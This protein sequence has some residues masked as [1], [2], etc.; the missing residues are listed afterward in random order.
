MISAKELVGILS[1]KI[2]RRLDELKQ[3]KEKQL[4]SYRKKLGNIES[5]ENISQ[6]HL[7]ELDRRLDSTL[8]QL[9]L[10]T[11]ISMVNDQ[12]RNFE[13]QEY[14][15]LAEKVKR[16]GEVKDP[17]PGYSP[18]K[19]TTET[20][21]DDPPPKKKTITISAIKP[22]YNKTFLEDHADV[23]EYVQALKAALLAELEK[24][25]SLLV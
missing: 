5:Y 2:N 11:Q 12:F 13:T 1:D 15:Y 16:W 21:I 7:D 4:D 6:D 14:P 17:D 8:R 19:P 24:G 9:R 23:E 18:D 25:N 3:E 20:I 22:R 10:T